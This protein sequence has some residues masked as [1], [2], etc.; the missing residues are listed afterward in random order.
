MSIVSMTEFGQLPAVRISAADGAQATVTLFGGHLVSWKTPDGQERLFCSSRSPL[1]GS[2]AIRG[3]VPLIFP[4][5]SERGPGMRHGFARLSTW[6]L[7]DSAL[8]GEAACADFHLAPADLP[9]ALSAAWP[10]GFALRLCVA[11]HANRLELDFE[12]ANTGPQS[13]DFSAALH[14][15]FGIADLASTSLAGVEGRVYEDQSVD[16]PPQ[17]EGPVRFAGVKLD[18]IYHGAAAPL[19]L[20]TGAATLR[21]EQSG[22]GDAV[23]WNPGAADAAKAADMDDQ[24]YLRFVCVEAAL[25]APT[26]LAGGARWQG[27]HTITVE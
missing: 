13:F 27:R 25:I 17:P 21:L 5:F 1:D 3:G 24:D 16:K 14:S 10:H 22:F 8:R 19:T 2:A 11:L 6:R 15:Y 9:A 20:S 7:G 23:V 12:V 26:T 18:R 4:Q